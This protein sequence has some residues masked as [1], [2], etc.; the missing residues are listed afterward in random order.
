MSYDSSKYQNLVDNK[1]HAPFA[2]GI[3]DNQQSYL[4]PPHCTPFARNFRV[5]G[6]SI[7]IRPWYS[8]V[9]D[10]T[11]GWYPHWIGSYLRASSI[12]DRL[13]VY[14]NL[15]VKSLTTD[16]TSTDCTGIT[17]TG[18]WRMNFTN[19]GDILYCMNW[20][21]QFTKLS[22]TTLTQ[23]I[24][25]PSSFAP[26]YSVVFNNTQW[27]GW[28]SSNSNIVYRSIPWTF[29]DFTG[30][31]SG[32]IWFNE[33]ITWLCSN[34]ESL[35]F[36]S[37]NSVSVTTKGD[38]TQSWSNFGYAVR[39][40]QAQEWAICHNSIV[41][42]WNAVFFLTPSNKIMRIEKG[43]SNLGFDTIDLTHR[44]N[45]WIEKIMNSLDPDQTNSFGYYVPSTNLCK[46]YLRSFWATF[47]DTCV[48]YSVNY[49]TFYV[50]TNKP[51]YDGLVHKWVE[52]TC[53]NI[54]AKVFQDELWQTD[55]DQA[56][57]FEYQTKAF[58]PSGPT[59]RN[60]LWESR[61]FGTINEL[62]ELVQEVYVD[63]NQV[64]TETFDKDNIPLITW[65]IGSNPIWDWAIWA[66]NSN[67]APD[68]FDIYN[69]TTKWKL[70]KKWFFFVWRYTCSTLGAKVTLRNLQ[71]KS[72]PLSAYAVPNNS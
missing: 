63:G 71:F 60:E 68:T 64:C 54:E 55:D 40:M 49:D 32:N 56:I 72:E 14:Q 22:W 4:L 2:G 44:K 5:N 26:S 20:T 17:F 58:N 13:A 57:Q 10:Y 34:L 8:T 70:Q 3:I 1:W 41:W 7:E 61:F 6:G 31:W 9:I 19:I 59:M 27:C 18:T 25:V 30:S 69:I 35:F 16:W 45:A 29:D 36:F 12:N 48:I 53:S 21:D 51:F 24:T 39:W 52:Y 67:N 28:W 38:I 62:A 43:M 50:D 46:W 15:K 47:N 11:S 42:A 66:Y 37:K 33:Q 65:G 23:P